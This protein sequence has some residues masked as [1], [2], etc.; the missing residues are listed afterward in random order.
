MLSVF[1]ETFRRCMGEGQEFV[2][3]VP[4][5]KGKNVID[6]PKMAATYFSPRRLFMEHEMQQFKD[7][8]AG[9]HA[10]LHERQKQRKFLKEQFKVLPPD[11]MEVYKKATREK[12]AMHG[13]I[14]EAIVD[15][16]N[17]NCE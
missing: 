7:S 5:N 3:R 4:F 15:T 1:Q 2:K 11:I 16:L 9:N 13:F 17:D 8:P 10:T 12:M 6:D 14:E